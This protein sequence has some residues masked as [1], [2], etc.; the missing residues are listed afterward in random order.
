MTAAA[1]LAAAL[2]FGA[3][4]T[5]ACNAQGTACAADAADLSG[6]SASGVVAGAA[7]ALDD[8]GWSPDTSCGPRGRLLQLSAGPP[9]APGDGGSGAA[10]SIYLSDLRP[11]VYPFTGP[12]SCRSAPGGRGFF[13]VFRGVDRERPA[14]AGA[15]TFD[16][17]DPVAAGSVDVQ[18]E[19]EDH[20]RGHFTARFC[21]S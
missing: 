1:A 4:C 2:L 20:L 21:G 7:V 12:I 17:G 13:A 16:G 6:T 9:C 19:G 15:V 3:G 10:L 8:S 5:A 18:L 11:G 14:I